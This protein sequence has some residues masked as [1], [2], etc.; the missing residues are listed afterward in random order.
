MGSSI[1]TIPAGFILV[2]FP[3]L[4]Q[5][6]DKLS[7]SVL[8]YCSEISVTDL[9]L[10]LLSSVLCFG[11]ISPEIQLLGLLLVTNIGNHR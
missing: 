11:S 9:L 3:F 8:H 5:E 7:T 4:C 1:N 10:E 2:L 6:N